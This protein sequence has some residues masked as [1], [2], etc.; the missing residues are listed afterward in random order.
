MKTKLLFLDID[1]VLN[2]AKTEDRLDGYVGL[3]KDRIARFN[4][5][6]EAVPDVKIVVSSTW[7]HMHTPSHLTSRG[8]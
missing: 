2:W 8:W 6:I 5:I 3:C 1:G 7:R 4:R